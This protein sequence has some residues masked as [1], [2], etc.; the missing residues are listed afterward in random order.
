MINGDRIWLT[1][2]Y[3]MYDRGRNGY[4]NSAGCCV[5]AVSINIYSTFA[6]E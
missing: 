1:P 5:D 4:L 6:D 3:D 2:A